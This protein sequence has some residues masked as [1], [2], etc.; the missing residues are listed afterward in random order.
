MAGLF[1]MA[2]TL[3]LVPTVTCAATLAIPQKV[4]IPGDKNLTD[5]QKGAED[6][7]E[8]ADAESAAEKAQDEMKKKLPEIPKASMPLKK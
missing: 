3:L 7:Q 8:Q 6:I 4:E 5:L 2:S 1:L